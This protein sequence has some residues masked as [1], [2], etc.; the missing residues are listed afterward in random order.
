MI[1]LKQ[2]G[3]YKLQAATKDKKDYFLF[4]GV[5]NAMENAKK[6]K[7]KKIRKGGFRARMR[8]KG[9]RKILARRRK[10]LYCKS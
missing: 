7:I 8:T 1:D 4:N 5:R 9:G 3:G 10:G 2:Q 6:S